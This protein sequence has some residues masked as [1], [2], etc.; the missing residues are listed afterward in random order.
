MLE[1]Y[2]LRYKDKFCF[3]DVVFVFN[4]FMKMQLSAFD[5]ETAHTQLI[6]LDVTREP[7]SVEL[8]ARAGDR[9][10]VWDAVAMCCQAVSR[11][12]LLTVEDRLNDRNRPMN[13]S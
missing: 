8:F 3:N 13:S 1:R 7:T 9:G 5:C 11:A 10:K 12:C 2:H 6:R 4:A